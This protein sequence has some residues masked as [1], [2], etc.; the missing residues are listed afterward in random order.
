MIK[1]K[2]IKERTYLDK[3]KVNYRKLD[4]LN[5]SMLKL[6][7][8][9]PIEFFNEFKLGKKRKHKTNTALIIGDIVDFYILQCGGDDDTFQNRFEEK[10]AL[11]Q[12]KKGTGQ[13]YQLADYL[14]EITQS[15]IEDDKMLISFEDAFKEAFDRM[16]AEDKYKKKTLDWALED[17]NKNGLDYYQAKLENTDK[18][19][20]PQSLMDK[21]LI[22][23]K[24]IMTDEFVKDIFLCSDCTDDIE[25]VT[26]FPIEWDYWLTETYSVKCKSE[27]DMMLIDH[28]R[29]IIQPMDL[30]TTFDNELFD[31]MYLK[32]GYYIQNAFYVKAVETWAKGPADLYDYKVMPMKFVVGDTSSNN[33]RPLVYE[34]SEED[35]K[36]GMYGFYYR[37]QKYRGVKELVDDIT[38]AEESGVWNCSRECFE[39]KG[40]LKLNIKYG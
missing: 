33:R 28:K 37:G 23:A 15:S 10:F 16:K 1:G 30:K 7:D 2:Q 32:N 40:I 11:F 8:E 3:P 34:T 6:F 4:A 20:V 24:N 36:A 38:W 14:F 12:G 39:K 25:F 26:H 35:I 17:F 13:V 27:L 22:V 31:T 18:V 5:Q 19:V 21:A 9:N 29:K